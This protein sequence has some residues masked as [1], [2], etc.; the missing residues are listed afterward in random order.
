MT[1]VEVVSEGVVPGLEQM[2]VRACWDTGRTCSGIQVEETTLKS[3]ARGVCTGSPG[4]TGGSTSVAFDIRSPR[5]KIDVQVELGLVLSVAGNAGARTRTPVKHLG[6]VGRTRRVVVHEEDA[7]LPSL[8]KHKD[9]LAHRHHIHLVGTG[10]MA[11]RTR[12]VVADQNSPPARRRRHTG[13]IHRGCRRDIVHVDGGICVQ[14][15]LDAVDEPVPVLPLPDLEVDGETVG[16]R[17][18]LGLSGGSN[19]GI[20]T[21]RRSAEVLVD[22]EGVGKPEPGGRT[23][24]KASTPINT[25]HLM[26]HPFARQGDP[27][28]ALVLGGSDGGVDPTTVYFRHLLR[29][30]VGT[31][32]STSS[33]S[34][35]NP[36]SLHPT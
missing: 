29:F 21:S 4:V 7:G 14:D 15:V 9:V 1:V 26:R 6:G 24:P 31:F 8:H 17:R 10:D 13:V 22:V 33:V 5:R 12:G 16:D 3:R 30:R 36:R 23:T 27:F 19:G 20:R 11:S 32:R 28:N 25:N 18:G 34:S 35:G 2:K